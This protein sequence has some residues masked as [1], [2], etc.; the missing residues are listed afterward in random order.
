MIK[1]FFAG[2]F[3]LLLIPGNL[4]Y[5][6]LSGASTMI[7][8]G[9]FHTKKQA[10]PDRTCSLE[11][12]GPFSHSHQPPVVVPEELTYFIKFSTSK[13]AGPQQDNVLGKF[14]IRIYAND[15]EEYLLDP[16]DGA[17][18]A[19]PKGEYHLY[20]SYLIYLILSQG[21]HHFNLDITGLQPGVYILCVKNNS[22]IVSKRWVKL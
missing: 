20:D 15:G 2:I 22:G 3:L 14:I 17:K 8:S 12:H 11:F 5:A 19:G 4:S 6:Q 7:Y 18:Q 1:K 9:S 10:Y 13:G 16:N 21:V